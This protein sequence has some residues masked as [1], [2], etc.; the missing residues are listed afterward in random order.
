[1]QFNQ[2]M[3]LGN[4]S[5]WN[6]VFF[7]IQWLDGYATTCVILFEGSF[8][9]WQKWVLRNS[10][11][12]GIRFNYF[13]GEVYYRAKVPFYLL[14]RLIYPYTEDVN[15]SLAISQGSISASMLF[16]H[17]LGICHS[18]SLNPLLGC[19]EVIKIRILPVGIVMVVNLSSG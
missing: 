10:D 11:A 12:C 3:K 4:D 14:N 17:L 9:F 16:C 15:Y 6:N 18:F 19:F 1:M 13:I 5:S 8:W 2:S 7:L